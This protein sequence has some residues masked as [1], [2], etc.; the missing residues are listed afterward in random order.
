MYW[1]PH[2]G[3]APGSALVRGIHVEPDPLGRETST[4]PNTVPFVFTLATRSVPKAATYMKF[5]LG[6]KTT[7]AGCASAMLRSAGLGAQP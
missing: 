6:S 4:K 7:P 2:S 5:P 3:P 1:R